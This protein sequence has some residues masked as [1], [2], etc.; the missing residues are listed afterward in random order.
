LVIAVLNGFILSLGGSALLDSYRQTRDRS[1]QSAQD[2]S[3]ALTE[4]VGG[5][6]DR[7]DFALLGIGDSF[8]QTSSPAEMR[9]L[10]AGWRKRVAVVDN[11]WVTD[12]S[13]KIRFGDKEVPGLSEIS[14]GDRDYF[15]HLRDDPASPM[16]ISK[17]VVGRIS[18]QW[19]I[20]LAR[21]INRPDGAFDGIA[22]AALPI[23]NVTAMFSGL[24]LGKDGAVALRADDL[25]VIARFP[26]TVGKSVAVGKT[27]VSQELQEAVQANPLAG[28]YLAKAG[29][30]GIE[31]ALSY[32]KIGSRPVTVV[33][34]L[35]TSDTMT[36][37]RRGAM[38]LM[39]G[40]AV[41][42]LLTV[43]GG[44]VISRIWRQRIEANK[45]L[46]A[47]VA[48][49]ER[50]SEILAHHLQE[51][52][53][54][55]HIFA[56]RLQTL[57][58]EPL[59]PEVALSLHHVLRGANRQRALLRDV[60]TFLALD[61]LLTAQP[62]SCD[63]E[64]ALSQ[65]LKKLDSKL[66]ELQTQLV[67]G[68]LPTAP[69]GEKPFI[70]LMTALLENAIQYRSPTRPLIIRIEGDKVGGLVSFAITDNGLGIAKPYRERV[71]NVFERL[72]P[73]PNQSGTGIGLAMVRKIV[74]RSGGWAEI[75]D[76]EDGGTR[77]AVHFPSHP[78]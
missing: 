63:A 2:L 7:I 44:A 66:Q 73:E 10:L 68:E 5:L 22:L 30:D 74:Q 53:R 34:G 47:M 1:V 42:A 64:A 60:R 18:Q 61:E 52:V 17:P 40:L 31:R 26:E 19:I 71:F 48:E 23:S 59:D 13:G 75:T 45:R 78:A 49:Q 33:V 32:H 24:H 21:R 77:V 51:P 57:L 3:V 46:Q 65:L 54:I 35:A 15:T 56:Q 67:I 4:G 29:I 36:D 8:R 72:N 50:F 6:F 55:Q 25:S 9:V 38:P 20:I 58:P 69:I 43:A 11:F 16:I 76:G 62:A 41:F 27:A 14:L 70:I 39:A 37:W 28:N 12:A